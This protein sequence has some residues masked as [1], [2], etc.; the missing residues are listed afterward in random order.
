VFER[1][2]Q[3]FSEVPDEGE[4]RYDHDGLGKGRA[5]EAVDILESLFLFSAA[6]AQSGRW[7]TE[8]L[9]GAEASEFFLTSSLLLSRH[10]LFMMLNLATLA[11]GA[12]T[13][14]PALID[15]SPIKPWQQFAN[16]HAR[17][18]APSNNSQPWNWAS[19]NRKM[20]TSRA[21]PLELG[22]ILHLGN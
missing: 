20:R 16:I 22:K 5:H 7:R 8:Y 14:L 12:L 21:V 1:V 6:C 9:G 3:G 10:I 19:G 18:A 11:A 17:Q 15:A 13:V 4:A 2:W